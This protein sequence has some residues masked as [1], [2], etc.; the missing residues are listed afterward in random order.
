MPYQDPPS[1]VTRMAQKQA[2]INEATERFRRASAAIADIVPTDTDV[3]AWR[4]WFRRQ[5]V[6]ARLAD[7]LHTF[8]SGATMVGSPE[9]FRN[10]VA[11]AQAHTSRIYVTILERAAETAAICLLEPVAKATA[12]AIPDAP[13]PKPSQVSFAGVISWGA[14][15]ADDIPSDVTPPDPSPVDTVIDSLARD[16]VNRSDR[17]RLGDALGKANDRADGNKAGAGEAFGRIAGR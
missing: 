14:F 4:D 11:R 2:C 10:Q 9:W 16:R 6:M 7:A 17:G 13:Q 5:V 8:D 3:E 1:D 12:A 15:I